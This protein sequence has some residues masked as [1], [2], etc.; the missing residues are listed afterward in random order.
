MKL[1]L[2]GLGIAAFTAMLLLPSSFSLQDTNSVQFWGASTLVTYDAE[3]NEIFAQ[4]VHNRILDAGEEFILDQVFADGS[5]DLDDV[6]QI[7][8]IC[9]LVNGTSEV[10]VEEDKTATEF[11]ESNRA[12]SN[13]KKPCRED[14]AVITSGGT[15]QIGA[16][17]FIG[18]VNLNSDGDD[19]TIHGI[20]ICQLNASD[21]DFQRCGDAN[22]GDN[23]ILFAIVDTSDVTLEENETVDITYTFDITSP[24]N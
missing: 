19:K 1:T 7:G 21:V 11:D 6:E 8:T 2:T 16:L 18:N 20:G 9:I 5:T 13:D 14:T 15:A 17:T 24:D 22:D 4:T 23:A 10:T 3:G 12:M